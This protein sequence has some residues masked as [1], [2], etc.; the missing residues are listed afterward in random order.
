MRMERAGA[1]IFLL[2]VF[3]VLTGMI[4]AL[5]GT[6]QASVSV[7]GCILIGPI[8]V[9]FG[10]GAEPLL[11]IIASAVALLVMLLVMYVLLAGLTSVSRPTHSPEE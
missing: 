1:L 8:P 3:L 7:G 9:C 10:Y 6:Q 11:L 5:L 4:L 2:G